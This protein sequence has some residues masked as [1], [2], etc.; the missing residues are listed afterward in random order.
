MDRVWRQVVGVAAITLVLLICL[1]PGPPTT[2]LLLTPQAPLVEYT[3][4]T[5]GEQVQAARRAAVRAE[6]RDHAGHGTLVPMNPY[7]ASKFYPASLT[8]AEEEGLAW[9][10]VGNVGTTAWSALF[11]L[12]RDIPVATI[13]AAVANLTAHDLLKQTFPSK[14]S[15]RGHM[16]RGEHGKDYFSFMVVRHPFVRLVSAY[17]DKLETVTTYNVRYHMK[18]APRM[19]ARR[20]H[21]SSVAASPT[22]QEFADYLV[23][24]LP[25][26]SR[27]SSSF[28]SFTFL[29]SSSS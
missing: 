25:S 17:R 11:L 19:T 1:L 20:T 4:R 22:F 5:T 15:E 24:L 13:R 8:L 9:C 7:F 14:P 26:S 16:V 18:D 29:F 12:L 6:C 28:S 21:N 23:R 3:G 10:R 2:P 27:S